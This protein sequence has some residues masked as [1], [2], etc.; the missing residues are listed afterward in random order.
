MSK[1]VYTIHRLSKERYIDLVKLHSAVHGAKAE[2][3][4]FHKKYET[5]FT[6]V[7]NVGFLAY[8][9][10]NKPIAYYGVT[11]CFL[12]FENKKILSAQSVDTMTH[13]EYRGR[14]LVIKL[15]NMT[16]DLSQALGIQLLFGFPNQNFYPIMINKLGWIETER[17]N[18]FQIPVSQFLLRRFFYNLSKDNRLILQELSSGGRF[19]D[20][21]VIQDG[22]IGIHKDPIYFQYKTFSQNYFVELASGKIWV[23]A[24]RQLIIGDMNLSAYDESVFFELR[25]L[26]KELSFNK[27]MFQVSKGCSLFTLFCKFYQPIPT[28][29]VVFKDFG[30]GIPLNKIKFTF[31]D[32]DIF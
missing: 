17:L 20:N 25:Y 29:P 11:P 26:A 13:P 28:F 1:E 6:G 15:S 19:M 27:I 16:F 5:S 7:E 32:I 30:A 14:G 31:S 18:C 23:K 3:D 8:E 9:K 12:Q 24:N 10:N 22:F 4:Y 21:S 2:D